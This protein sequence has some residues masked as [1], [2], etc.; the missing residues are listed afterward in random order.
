MMVKNKLS[1]KRTRPIDV[2]HHVVRDAE[3]TGTINVTYA[4]TE[5]PHADVLTKA[6]E[7][8][9]FEKQMKFLINV[10]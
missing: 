9:T 10:A 2:E 5:D 4:R 1:S 7:K 6:F 8:N 3:T